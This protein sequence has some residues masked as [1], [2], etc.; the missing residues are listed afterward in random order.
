[1]AKDDFHVIVYQIL[2][3][4][5]QCLK[6]GAEVDTKMLAADSSYFTIYGKPLSDRYWCY[7]LWQIQRMGLIEG[8]IFSGRVD[9]Y[10]FERPLRWEGCMI[11]PTG[12]EYLTD[13][14][15]LQKVKE[16]LK[17]VKAITPFV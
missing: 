1:M 13:N 5:Y 2:S 9:N 3:Y 15:F 14:S 16:F 11:T 4:L 17:D 8:V 12:I 6:N 10:P 7:I